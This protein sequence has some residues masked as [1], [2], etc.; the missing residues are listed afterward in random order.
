M[1]LTELGDDQDAGEDA[2]GMG[3]QEW[4]AIA[5]IGSALLIGANALGAFGGRR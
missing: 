2:G 3:L 5:S 1:H 4:A